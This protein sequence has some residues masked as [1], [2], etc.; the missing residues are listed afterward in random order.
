MYLQVIKKALK[1]LFPNDGVFL[2]HGLAIGFAAHVNTAGTIA[3]GLAHMM[4]NE[5]VGT[6]RSGASHL[7]RTRRRE[8]RHNIDHCY[9]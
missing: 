5:E 6:Q 3:W 2:Q 1:H 8:Q 7:S 9:R 4:N